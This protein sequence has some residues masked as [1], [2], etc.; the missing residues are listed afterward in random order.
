VTD[1]VLGTGAKQLVGL[2]DGTIG[3][4]TKIL[5]GGGVEAGALRVT[6][7]SDSTGVLS[8]D[9]NG[10]SL[11]VD[12]TVTAAQGTAANLNMTEASAAAIKTAVEVMD[13]WDESDR[14]KV[15]PIVG[16]A[17]VQGASGAVSATTQRVVLAT[18]VALPT[19]ANAIGKL[20]ANTGVDIGDVDVTSIVPGTAATNLGKAE[21]A[22]HNSGDTGVYALAV[23]DTVPAAHAGTDG[24]YESFHVSDEGGLWSAEVA[25]SQGGTDVFFTYDADETEEDVKTSAGTVYGWS[26]YNDGAAEVYV[27]LY[28]ATAANTTVGSTAAKMVLGIPAGSGANAMFTPGIKFD[29]A[30][31]IAAT[32]LTGASDTTAP[33]AN[34]VL[35]TIF[36]K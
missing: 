14:A 36:Y 25:S 30:I 5:A 21:D 9:D 18:D 31:C 17:G 26:I 19:G 8:V 32:T 2:V 34:Q 11:T 33:A 35:A 22:T 3:S 28:N 4:T 27:R 7:A 15:N 23:R 20:A 13:D 24:E 6:V 29:T 10:G 16:Q 1:G 12:G